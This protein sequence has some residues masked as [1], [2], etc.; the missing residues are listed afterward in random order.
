MEKETHGMYVC[1]YVC[2]A[3]LHIRAVHVPHIDIEMGVLY[4][5]WQL[6]LVENNIL[7]YGFDLL[8][9]DPSD[10]NTTSTTLLSDDTDDRSKRSTNPEPRISFQQEQEVNGRKTLLG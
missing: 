5:C 9:S 7:N 10:A 2:I 1:M 4:L 8:A 3:Q 6:G